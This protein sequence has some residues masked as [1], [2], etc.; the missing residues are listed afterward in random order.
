M[1]R[2]LPVAGLS[3]VLGLAACGEEA[4]P[5]EAPAM[6]TVAAVATDVAGEVDAVAT[7]MSGKVDTAATGVAGQVDA[8]STQIAGKVDSAATLAAEAAPTIASM[9][10]G[11]AG[12]IES[13]ATGVA[14]MAAGDSDLAGTSWQWQQTAMN[15]DTMVTP[16]NAANYSLTFTAGGTVEVKADCN[17]G[18]GPY[19]ATGS[20]LTIGPLAT[21]RA[22]CPPGSRSELY[23]AQLQSAAT[24]LMHDGNLLID[25][26]ADAGTM[27][28]TP[29]TSTE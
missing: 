26:I 17:S 3:L 15:N 2:I 14:G 7:D 22:A 25:L 4:A 21:T 18:G 1:K 27:T 28:F 23:L 19:T 8:A 29:L 5:T 11:A 9:A 12:G 16:D 24:Y 13:A 20:A 10:T 6:P